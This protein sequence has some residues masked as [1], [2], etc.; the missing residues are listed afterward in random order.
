MRNKD[1]LGE[2]LKSEK[3]GFLR[4]AGK[5]NSGKGIIVALSKLK[6]HQAKEVKEEVLYWL[7]QKLS[8]ASG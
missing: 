8:F 2:A 4:K 7:S 3:G 6:N 1:T 5:R